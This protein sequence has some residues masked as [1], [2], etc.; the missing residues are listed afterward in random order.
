MKI[1]GHKKNVLFDITILQCQLNK[2]TAQ[3]ENAI[4]MQMLSKFLMNIF[5]KLQMF[6]STASY[7]FLAPLNLRYKSNYFGGVELK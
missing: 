1:V 5:E 3:I 7:D 4:L 2:S 6:Y